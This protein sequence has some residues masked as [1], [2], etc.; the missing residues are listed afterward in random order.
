MESIQCWSRPGATRVPDV[1]CEAVGGK[2]DLT[3]LPTGW[4]LKSAKKKKRFTSKQTAFL[5]EQFQIGG[6][7]GRK[8]DPQEVSKAMAV[9]RRTDGARL[10]PPDEVLTK[11]Q[12]SGFFSRLSAKKRLNCPVVMENDDEDIYAAETETPCVPM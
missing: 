11:Q 6:V 5:T 1:Q 9:T 8:V 2:E 7:S 12:I 4:A 10:F 3:A